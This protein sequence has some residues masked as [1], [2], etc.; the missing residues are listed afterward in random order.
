MVAG[1]VLW[2][3][4]FGPSFLSI[5]LSIFPSVLL[6]GRFRGIV[7]LVFSKFLHG[8]RNP[9]EIGMTEPDFSERFFA[10]KIGKMDHKWARNR[11]V[12]IY[13]KI[14]SL[15]FTEFVLYWKFILFAVF[16]HKSLIGKILVPDIWAK[17]FSA[18]QIAGFFNQPY[19]Q[20]KS[21]KQPDFLHVDTNSYKL[22][23]DWKI[24][25]WAWSEMGVASLVTVVG[26]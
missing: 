5:F 14:L 22:K 13:W 17:M 3:M 12:W 18:N 7:S 21:M 19:L 25:G 11:V 2:N 26:L 9:Y 23:I 20:N 1:R 16:L 8:T 15:I 10:P 24:F 6:S 4:V